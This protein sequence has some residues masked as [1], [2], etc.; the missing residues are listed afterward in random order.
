M[1]SPLETP[2]DPDIR[3]RAFENKSH[4]GAHSDIFWTYHGPR[5]A[6][7]K[8]GSSP[9]PLHRRTRQALLQGSHTAQ[10]HSNFTIPTLRRSS[11]HDF[12]RAKISPVYTKPFQDR[13][14]ATDN[15]SKWLTILDP[16]AT[17]KEIWGCLMVKCK[18]QDTGDL[19]R[20][21]LKT[22]AYPRDKRS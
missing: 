4:C 18:E 21:Y 9:R 3:D 15:S 14:T 6:L 17:L 5:P 22:V 11:A 1:R 20:Q 13:W 2:P 19:I 8:S 7:N 12:P 10:C 16:N